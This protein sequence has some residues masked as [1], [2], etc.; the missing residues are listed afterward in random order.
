[1]RKL[2]R[3]KTNRWIAGVCGGL[4][5]YFGI[6]PIL[7]RIIFFVT[8]GLG[9][10]YL[11][12]WIFIPENP[13]QAASKSSISAVKIILIFLAAIVTLPFIYFFIKNFFGL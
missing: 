8:S 5:E 9:G 12:L 7:F 4:G 3:S 11:L 10:A 2:Y 1:M 13:N 6:D